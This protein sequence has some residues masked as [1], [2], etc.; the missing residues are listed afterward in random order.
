VY[1]ADMPPAPAPTA[2]DQITM[3][4]GLN[5]LIGAW[6]FI[7]AFW[8]DGTGRASWNDVILGAIVFILG[9]IA[10]SERGDRVAT[11]DDPAA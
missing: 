2:R 11:I 1:G 10:W 5:V 4:A 8:L 9:I 3:P 6:I 7:S